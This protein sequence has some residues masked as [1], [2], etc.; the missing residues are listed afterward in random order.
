MEPQTWRRDVE[1]APWG[2]VAALRRRPGRV[3]AVGWFPISC[4]DLELM[5][6]DR[7][8]EV[9]RA[10]LLTSVLAAKEGGD[11]DGYLTGD[12]VAARVRASIVQRSATPA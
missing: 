10:E 11:R 8:V 6:L 1:T 9:V 2:S 7:G 3:D 12:E 4:R 5:L